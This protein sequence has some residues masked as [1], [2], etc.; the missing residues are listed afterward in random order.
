[1]GTALRREAAAARR[2]R[3]AGRLPVAPQAPAT[4]ASLGRKALRAAAVEAR[5]AACVA[6]ARET[7]AARVALVAWEADA[8]AGAVTGARGD[9]V[10]ADVTAM[11]RPPR[12]PPAP[13]EAAVAEAADVPAAL[14]TAGIELGEAAAAAGAVAAAA[15]AAAE[16]GRAT[17]P[18]PVAGAAVAAL[19]PP[20]MEADM[21]NLGAW[22]SG[23][24][25]GRRNAACDRAHGTLGH[26]GRSQSTTQ[27]VQTA[28][29]V[30]GRAGRR[31]G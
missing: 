29:D 17:G 13:A 10:A 1:M 12:E 3:L 28:A 5:E 14:A 26:R 21:S 8:W 30:A 11:P 6:E 23:E 15:A 22:G 19:A 4:G 7:D 20:L 2:R 18:V 27:L 24:T 25:G 16:A 9:V 31:A